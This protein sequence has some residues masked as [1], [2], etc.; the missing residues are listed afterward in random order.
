[1][2]DVDGDNRD[3]QTGQRVRVNDWPREKIPQGAQGVHVRAK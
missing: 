1:V 2:P 3:A